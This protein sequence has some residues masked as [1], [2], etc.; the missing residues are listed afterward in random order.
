MQASG[1]RSFVVRAGAAAAAGALLSGAASSQQGAALQVQPNNAVQGGEFW[2]NKARLVISISMQFE[3]G[4]QPPKGTDS[5]FPKV[6]MPASV[7]AD[8]AANT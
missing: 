6:D 8:L 7:L 5:P 4:G 1:R 2:P 3:A